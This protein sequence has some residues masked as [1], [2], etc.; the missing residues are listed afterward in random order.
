LSRLGIIAAL[1]A[2]AKCLYDKK[3]E[4]NSPHEIEKDIFLCLSGI[5]Y[6]PAQTSANSL[7]ELNV[8]ALISWGVA[9]AINNSVGSG[10]VVIANSIINDDISYPTT[11]SWVEAISAGLDGSFCKILNADIA[12]SRDMCASVTDKKNL[13]NKTAALAV[14]MESVAIAEVAK[15]Y[16]LDFLVIRS[17]ADGADRGIPEAVK[18]YTDT[19]GNPELVKFILS[20]ILKPTQICDI[21]HLAN[22][23]RAG[24]KSLISIAPELKKRHF[25]HSA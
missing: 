5:G 7:L 9:G 1:P 19:L 21:A 10:D 22:S 17:I 11:H 3:L 13:F 14:D 23:Y 12:S 4:L 18:N 25:F 24:L 16:H 2:E 20:C 8:D 6:E 15:K